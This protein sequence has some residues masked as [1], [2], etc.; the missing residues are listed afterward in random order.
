M[1][2]QFFPG[3]KTNKNFVFKKKQQTFRI[4][5]ALSTFENLMYLKQTTAATFN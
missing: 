5:I 1:M 3:K 2:Q 4:S